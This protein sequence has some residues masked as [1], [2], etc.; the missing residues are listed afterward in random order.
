MPDRILRAIDH[1]IID[2]RSKEF[3][4]LGKECLNGLKAVFQTQ[5]VT[6]IFPGSATGAWEAAL[7]N[8]L[9]PR[10]RVLAFETGHFANLWAKMA[11]N[12]DLQIDLIPGDWRHG[13]NI[14]ALADR[15]SGDS[16][17]PH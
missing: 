13:V 4:A 7:V 9:S 15:L 10:D 12:L 14:S 5:G 6:V 11:H 16:E 8:T 1:P 17:S 2:H 3:G